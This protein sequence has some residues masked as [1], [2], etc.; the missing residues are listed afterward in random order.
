[1]CSKNKAFDTNIE[2]VHSLAIFIFKKKVTNRS[3]LDFKDNNQFIKIII[4]FQFH[5]Y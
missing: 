1:M 4:E 3:S 2:K 5:Y